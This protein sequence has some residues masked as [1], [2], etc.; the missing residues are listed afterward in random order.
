MSLLNDELNAPVLEGG[1]LMG[2][3]SRPSGRTVENTRCYISD[4]DEVALPVREQQVMGSHI[5]T[6]AVGIEDVYHY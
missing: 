4:V 1:T 3:V 5:G 2:S 6:A